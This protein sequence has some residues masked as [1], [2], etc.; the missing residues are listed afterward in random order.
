MLTRKYRIHFVSY[1]VWEIRHPDGYWIGPGLG[2]FLSPAAAMN[3][4]CLR[5]RE[6][7]R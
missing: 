5:L 2:D 7:Q 6:D 4:L 3:W 1:G